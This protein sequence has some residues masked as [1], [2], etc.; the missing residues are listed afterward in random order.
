MQWEAE[1]ELVCALAAAPDV[2][3]P[4]AERLAGMNWVDSQHE[5]IVWAIMA[6]P[7]G[8]SPQDAVAAATSVVSWAPELLSSGRIATSGELTPE[9]SARLLVD[10]CDLYSTKRAIRRIRA[11][12]AAQAS[13]EDMTALFAEAS[14][15]QKKANALQRSVSSS[16]DVHVPK[17]SE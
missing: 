2:M 1:L 16:R 4:Y 5:A 10:T 12:L 3:R 14:E 8:T 6:T 7:Q 17:K 9:E 11:Q 13:D 15:L